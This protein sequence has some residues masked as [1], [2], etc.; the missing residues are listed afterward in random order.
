MVQGTEGQTQ[1]T[2]TGFALGTPGYMS[3]EQ[4]RGTPTDHRAD[5]YAVGVVLYHMVT[6]DKP[7]VADSP[8]AVLRMHMDDP[9][10]PPR[11]VAPDAKLSAALETV[12]LRALEKEPA[13]RWQSAQDFADALR[14][15]KEGG[16]SGSMVDAAT[17][18]AAP[19]ARSRPR[20]RLPRW[21]WKVAAVIVVAGVGLAAWSHLSHRE[22]QKVKDTLDDAVDKTKD[23]LKSLKPPKLDPT[24][25]QPPPPPPKKKDDDEDKPKFEDAVRLVESNKPDEAIKVLYA[26]RKQMPQSAGV[27]LWLGHAYFKKMWRADALEEYAKALDGNPSFRTDALLIRNAI[28]ALDDAQFLLARAVLRK[29]GRPAL[30]E[31]RRTVRE[32]KNPKLR[33]RANRVGVEIARARSR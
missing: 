28:S 29:V 10:K 15:T 14:S 19:S 23:V 21:L 5:L 33:A 17:I 3:P 32:T 31:L 11:K 25:Q 30:P 22:Q 20:R 16:G 6:G 9:P 8:M 13:R 12:I 26:L 18:A 1:L 4:A 27:A 2:N 24:E 7:F